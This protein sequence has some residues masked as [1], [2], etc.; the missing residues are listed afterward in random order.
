MQKKPG[1]NGTSKPK[2]PSAI[3]AGSRPPSG[4][5]TPRVPAGVGPSKT[6]PA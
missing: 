1:T 4:S 6:L 5:S 3:S 2:T